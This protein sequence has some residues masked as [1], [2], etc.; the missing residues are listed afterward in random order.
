[1]A[2]N[3]NEEKLRKLQKQ[4]DELTN[5]LASTVQELTKAKLQLEIRKPKMV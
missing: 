4:V 2:K 5:N 3:E 1:M